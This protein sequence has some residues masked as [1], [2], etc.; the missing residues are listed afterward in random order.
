MKKYY[1]IS[2]KEDDYNAKNMAV[3]YE[4]ESKVKEY[5]Y[6]CKEIPKEDFEVLKKYLNDVNEMIDENLED[7]L[8]ENFGW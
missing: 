1:L 2:G 3:I 8:E 4:K 6:W 7:Y 5:V